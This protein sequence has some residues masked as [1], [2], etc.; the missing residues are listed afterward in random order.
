MTTERRVHVFRNGRNQTL[1]ISRELELPGRAA[2]VR[3]EGSRLIIE[4]V[5]GPSLLAVH[6]TLEPLDE[7]LPPVPRTS[8]ESMGF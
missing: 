8:A 2:T 7:N 1:R 4:P 3:K 5:A 6:A